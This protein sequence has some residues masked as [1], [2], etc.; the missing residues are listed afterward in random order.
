VAALSRRDAERLLRFVAVAEAESLG[1]EQPFTPE[2]LVELGGLV[3]ADWVTYCELDRVR[4]RLISSI[5]RAGDD[6]SGEE[7][8]APHVFWQIVIEEHPVCVQHQRGDFR[9]LKVSDFRTRTQLRRSCL[10]DAW[11]RPLGVEHEL[12]VPIPSP[13][14]HTKTFLFD[15]ADGRDFTERDR[16]V[17]DLLQPHL[18][19][20]WETAQT[21]RLLKAA[22]ARLD[23]SEN[24]DSSGVILLAGGE[25]PGFTS[26]SARRLI[27]DFF[28]AGAG[29]RLP[30][31]LARWLEAGAEQPFRQDRNERVLTVRREGDALLLRERREVVR[32]TRREREVLSWVARGKTNAQVAELLWLSPSTVRK[33]LENVYPKLGVNTRTAA[34]ASFLGLIDAEAS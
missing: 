32:L 6:Y 10:Y 28:Q 24:S 19:R 29:G 1:D 30:P 7:E 13:L 11:F 21:R 18:A 22:L 27:R 20:L 34:V 23:Q 2:L 4:L 16:L 26:P 3:E 31:A 8:I 9:A 17:L 15:R 33:H 25:S 12:N 14:W 5:G